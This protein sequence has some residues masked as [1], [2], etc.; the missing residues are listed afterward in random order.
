MYSTIHV[1]VCLTAGEGGQSLW[2][3]PDLRDGLDLVKTLD[4]Y[5]DN[6][7]KVTPC[8]LCLICMYMYLCMYLAYASLFMNVREY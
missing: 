4:P 6:A 7:V 5:D 8:E 2:H 1:D 3:I